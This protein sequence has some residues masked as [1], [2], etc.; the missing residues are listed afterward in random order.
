MLA[1]PKKAAEWVQTIR[2][3]AL[4]IFRGS[5]VALSLLVFTTAMS[6]ALVAGLDAGLIYN[7]FPYMGLGL[8]PPKSE[9]FDPFYSHD[10]SP[11]KKDL[12]WRNFLENP[13]LV[14]LDHR[15]LATSTFTAVHLLWAWSKFS[16]LSKTLPASAKRGIHGLVGLVWMQA[17]LGI[18]TLIYMIPI[19]IASAHQAGA[20]ALLTW[21]LVVFKRVS[22]PKEAINTLARRA[23]L[24]AQM[25]NKSNTA[26]PAAQPQGVVAMQAGIGAMSLAAM[27]SMSSYDQ[28]NAQTVAIQSVSF[29]QDQV[30][31]LKQQSR[32][33]AVNSKPV[34]I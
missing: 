25:L 24:T 11:E 20:L 29:N 22:V 34:E 10:P 4:R 12:I 14:Q 26:T 19:P 16:S 5:V 32:L 31:Y 23:G 2:H 6:G 30:S 27:T 13:S 7:E 9:L 8:T 15:I 28:A 3:P 17:T 18:S 33:G 21:T 1:D